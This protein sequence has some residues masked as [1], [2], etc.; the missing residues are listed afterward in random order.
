MNGRHLILLLSLLLTTCFSNAAVLPV[1]PQ[2]FI[3]TAFDLPVGGQKFQVSTSAAFQTALNSSKAGDIIELQA[4]VTFKGPFTLPNKTMGLGWIYI[5]SSAYSNLPAPCNRVG[6]SDTINMPKLTVVA[7]N[8]GAINT[9]ANSNHYRFVG[10]EFCPVAGNYVYNIIN[11]GNGEKTASTQPNNLVFDRCYIH[12]DPVKGSR[13]GLLMNGSYISVI[14]CYISDCKE[15]GADSQALAAYSTTG[16]IKIVNNY[17]EGAGENIIFGGSDPS[18]PN[19]VASDIEIRCNHIFKPL[20]WMNEL[21]DIKNLFELKN[22]QRVLI[23]GNRLENCW[24][25]AQSGFAMVL[26]PRN[27]NNTAPWSVVQDVTIRF[28]TFVNVAQG[29]NMAGHD[30]PNI[31]QRTSRILV[32]NNVLNVTNLGTGGDGRMFMVLSGPIDVTFDHNTGFTTNAYMVSDGS[33]KTDNFVFNNNLVTY[34]NYGFI[35]SGTGSANTTLS[36]YFNPNWAVTNNA[37]I[38]GSATGYP[39]GSFFPANTAAVKFVDFAGGNY[40]L[41]SSSPYK[42]ASTDGKDIGADIDSIVIASIYKCDQL[43]NVS[44]IK[45]ATDQVLLYPVPAKDFLNIK[46]EFASE[47]FSTV[48]ITDITGKVFYNKN[49]PGSELKIDLMELVAGIYIL[50]LNNGKHLVNKT[51]VVE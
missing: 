13:R 32:Q 36:T 40:R 17:L 4:G 30:A 15:D 11:I 7:N 41:S 39:T 16:P 50:K 19:A 5:I 38:G 49:L 21:W 43:T 51:F 9:V 45:N 37:I 23:E 35:G 8:G 46:T 2:I 10:I 42:N 14:D 34:A 33:P 47:T 12:G 26:T 48:T 44:R 27:Q 3:Q 1:L 18:I 25:N 6:I 24:P 22:A 28:N 31:S 20:K 29:I